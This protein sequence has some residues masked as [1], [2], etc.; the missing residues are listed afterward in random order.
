MLLF[1][2][3]VQGERAPKNERFVKG[4][5]FPDGFIYVAQHEECSSTTYR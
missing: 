2:E 4:P 5:L 3:E 1:M